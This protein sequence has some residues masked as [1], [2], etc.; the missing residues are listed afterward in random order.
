M[1]IILDATSCTLVRINRCFGGVHCIYLHGSSN[2]N[3][4]HNLRSVL[5]TA[6]VSFTETMVYCSWYAVGRGPQ[7]WNLRWG[8]PSRRVLLVTSYGHSLFVECCNSTSLYVP[9]WLAPPVNGA[10]FTFI[11]RY[12][13]MFIFC[14]ETVAG[15]DSTV[16]L[17]LPY[18][19]C[20]AEWYHK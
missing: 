6:V 1:P 5:K 11:Y 17:M 3:G 2:I 10:Q 8:Y 19:S 9:F 16:F 20:T 4:E 13:F 18:G 14:C 15:A 12:R 7:D